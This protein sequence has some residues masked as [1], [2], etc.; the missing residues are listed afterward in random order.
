MKF[1]Q[2]LSI[3]SVIADCLS[4]LAL[5]SSILF[6]L[7]IYWQGLRFELPFGTF[8]VRSPVRP[9]LISL[10][11]T[12]IY[13]IISSDK[14]SPVAGSCFFE[15]PV[16]FLYGAAGLSLLS[17]WLVIRTGYRIHNHPDLLPAVLIMYG[18]AWA[19]G[20]RLAWLLKTH[21]STL[22]WLAGFFWVISPLFLPVSW[23]AGLFFIFAAV[24]VFIPARL[25]LVD[26]PDGL[27]GFWRVFPIALGLG[28]LISFFSGQSWSSNRLL[29]SL[30][31]M[32]RG[33]LFGP[34]LVVGF[35]SVWKERKRI[36]A[37][38]GILLVISGFSLGLSGARGILG[39]AAIAGAVPA[40]SFLYGQGG[41]EI[42][43]WCD[44]KIRL[45]TLNICLIL[46]LGLGLSWLRFGQAQPM[47][48]KLSPP[49]NAH[50]E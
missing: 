27:S 7:S 5:L 25:F 14:N 6:F 4:I 40:L 35:F 2:N 9:F 42:L 44:K 37:P 26:L 39:T 38:V 21:R 1:K 28:A 29:D 15:K 46:L 23:L 36:S 11:L 30:A 3:R 22:H 41:Q 33:G 32:S 19:G 47:F 43:K 49:V 16:S 50:H 12:G 48:Q 8:S 17:G 45:F 18:A 31:S 34:V 10:L 20:L 24:G 13:Q